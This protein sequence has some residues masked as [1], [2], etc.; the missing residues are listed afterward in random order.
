MPP[1]TGPYNASKP[2]HEVVAPPYAYTDTVD[3]G[4]SLVVEL[5]NVAQLVHITSEVDAKLYFSEAAI[6]T[7]AYYPILAGS[8][9]ALF[10]QCKEAWIRND[11]GGSGFIGV[12]PSLSQIKAATWPTP[13]EAEGFDGIESHASARVA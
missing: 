3:D 9:V 12:L 10:L 7:K 4:K 13:S 11:S 2:Q 1:V 6:G 8:P 5:H